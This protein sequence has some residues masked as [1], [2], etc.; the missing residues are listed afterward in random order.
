MNDEIR[1]EIRKNL[2]KY[3][4]EKGLSQK[5]LANLLKVNGSAVSIWETGRNSIDI[6]NLYN[7]CKIL[8]ISFNDILGKYNNNKEENEEIRE[9]NELF[10]K[11]NSENKEFIK[12]S[13]KL[14]NK[15]QNN[16]IC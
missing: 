5:E 11:L 8:D 16:N 13:L 9:V 3:R 6:N 10:N 2:I 12:T 4:K 7:I 14:A 1:E 15:S